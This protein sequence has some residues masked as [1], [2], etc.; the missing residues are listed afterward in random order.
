VPLAFGVLSLLLG[1]VTQ[2][3]VLGILS[4]GG[5]R[6]DLVLLVVL[7]WSMLRGVPEG[8]I[9]GIIGGMLLDVL[10]AGPFGLYTTLLGVIA[11]CTALGESNLY[12]GNVPL[13]V[14]TAGLAT[15][16]LHGGEILGLQLAWHNSLPANVQQQSTAWQ[17]PVVLRFIQFVVP[18]LA[19]NALLM[20]VVFNVIQRAVRVLSGWRQLEL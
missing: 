14:A 6:A 11:A 9:I 12:R 4:N 8:A 15:V 17:G 5:P 18:T 13:F 19:L 16:A 10:S 3:T 1:A 2:V 20:P 7:A